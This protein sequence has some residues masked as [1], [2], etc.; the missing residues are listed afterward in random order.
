MLRI[1]P[2]G[3]NSG[4]GTHISVGMRRQ[5]LPV[6]KLDSSDKYRYIIKMIHSTDKEKDFIYNEKYDWTGKDV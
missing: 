1:F 2:N 3:W 4:E 6:L 5:K